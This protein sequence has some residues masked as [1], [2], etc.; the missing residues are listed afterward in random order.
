MASNCYTSLD[1][2]LSHRINVTAHKRN[3]LNSD[4]ENFTGV[5]IVY[6]SNNYLN[7]FG[8]KL[9]YNVLTCFISLM[10]FL[11]LD[12]ILLSDNQTDSS[13]SDITLPK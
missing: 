3:F 5:I 11:S 6:L 10:T 7:V 2:P 12:F 8:L 9:L 4:L 1:T 13:K